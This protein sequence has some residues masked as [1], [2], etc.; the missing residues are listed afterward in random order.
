VGENGER[1][2]GPDVRDS[3]EGYRYLSIERTATL[4]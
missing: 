1:L 4:K 3:G 2:V